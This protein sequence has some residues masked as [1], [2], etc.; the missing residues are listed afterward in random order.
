MNEEGTGPE[1][2]VALFY[3][4]GSWEYVRR[5]VM[6]EQAVQAAKAHCISIGGRT[7]LVQRVI[8]T[9][10]GDDCVFEWKHGQGVT[11]PTPEEL[12]GEKA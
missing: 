6:P 2:S 3:R 4:D 7:G 11:F 1:Y 10:G 9:D 5:F 8:I 12:R